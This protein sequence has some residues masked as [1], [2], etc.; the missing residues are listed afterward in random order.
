M[1]GLSAVTAFASMAATVGSEEKNV[2]RPAEPLESAAPSGMTSPTPSVERLATSD[3][4]VGAFLT[5]T[6]TVAEAPPASRI[7]MV[8]VPVFFAATV[9][10]ASTVATPL[11]FES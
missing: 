4:E 6:D 3:T 9:P 7:A 1:P 8:A 10:R 11:L 5:V 2:Q